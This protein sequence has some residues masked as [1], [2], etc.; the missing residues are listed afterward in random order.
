[1][2]Y[3]D[4]KQ[5]EEASDH[6][7]H[8]L[9][10]CREIGDQ[11]G[12]AIALLNIGGAHRKLQQFEEALDYFQRALDVACSVRDRSGEAAALRNLGASAMR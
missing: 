2:P 1:M 10:L 7:R 4:L 8:K 5:Y 11:G 6:F 12:E 9:S 3:L